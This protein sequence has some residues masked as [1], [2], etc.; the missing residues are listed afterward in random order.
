M[1]TLVHE[2]EIF[3]SNRDEIKPHRIYMYKLWVLLIWALGN[4]IWYLNFNLEVLNLKTAVN[5]QPRHG[6]GATKSRGHYDLRDR[7]HYNLYGRQLHQKLSYR[8]GEHWNL[9]GTQFCLQICARQLCS[10]STAREQEQTL[11]ASHSVRQ[12]H[13]FCRPLS[14]RMASDWDGTILAWTVSNRRYDAVKSELR[15]DQI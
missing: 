6:G 12:N 13:R 10:Y 1:T 9:T 4:E 7:N 5:G 8:A 15:F 14:H 3:S 2:P 11:T